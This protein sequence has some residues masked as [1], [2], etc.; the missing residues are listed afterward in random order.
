LIFKDPERLNTFLAQY[1]QYAKE[2]LQPTQI[3]IM[4]LFE[5]WE[6]PDYWEKYKRT[7]RISTPTPIQGIFSRIK[8]P[9]QVV[10]K[11][12]R[13]PQNYPGDLTHDNIRNM[14]DA[15]GF[16]VL[17][18]FLCHLPLVDRE[19]QNSD[20]FEISPVEPPVVY[21]SEE[22]TKVLSLTHLNRITKESGYSSVH[23]T[24]RLKS[25]KIPES[26]R[27]WFE[28][29]I[30][31]VAQQLWCVTEHHL[32][33]KPV[34]RANVAAK[35]QFKILS[36]MINALDEQFNFL[37]EELNRYQ[38]EV[39][40]QDSDL[41][42]AKN[43]PS[44]LAEIGLSCAQRDINNILKFLYSRGVETVNDIQKIAS[45]KN[46]AIIRN[47]YL[48]E[49]GRQPLNLEMIATLAALK[50]SPTE[51]EEVKLI[52]SQ[53]AYRGAW[54]EIQQEFT[55]ETSPKVSSPSGKVR[56]SRDH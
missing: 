24:L 37:Y 29:Q 9:E 33:Y 42:D 48:S 54:D 49:T 2:I 20:Q 4:E 21:M 47:T 41:L 25:S 44:V 19:I 10:D 8:R 36:K 23:Y 53:I 18:Y 11:I 28:L 3:E 43:I 14:H 40:Y 15:I 12:F 34:K 7:S 27:P 5:Q 50:D 26:E 52:K 17:V 32:G 38:E 6:I 16:R 35:R 30:R 31:T 55:Q 51:E 1:E 13:Q 39:S 46:L 56:P 45:P 22:Q